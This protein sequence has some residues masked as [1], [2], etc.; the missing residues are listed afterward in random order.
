[1]YENPRLEK[2]ERNNTP[3]WVLSGDWTRD[4]PS[5]V[6]MELGTGLEA[7]ELPQR[8]VVDS[9]Y[10]A[11][12]DSWGEGKIADLV[13][14]AVAHGEVQWVHDPR[15]CSDCKCS[16][17]QDCSVKEGILWALQCRRIDLPA[18]DSVEE[19]FLQWEK[20]CQRR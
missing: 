17:P 13:Q 19:A 1:M 10:V 7:A 6:R 12:I 20:Q 5:D 3:L 2:K 11:F 14:R 18:M 16:P 9:S 4:L 8:L 15:G